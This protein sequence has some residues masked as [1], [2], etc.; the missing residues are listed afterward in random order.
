MSKL[1]MLVATKLKGFIEYWS[2]LHEHK[3]LDPT[4][5]VLKGVIVGPDVTIGRYTYIGANSAI[6]SG[7]IGAFCSISTNVVIGGDDHSMGAVSTHPFWSAPNGWTFSTTD[8]VDRWTQPKSAPV[9]GNDV[10]IGANAVVLRGAV[11]EDGAVIGAGAVV[12]GKIP[13]Y[14]IAVGVP[15]RVIRYRFPADICERLRQS[16]WW[17]W[18]KERLERMR[19]SFANVDEFLEALNVEQYAKAAKSS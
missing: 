6:N 3:Y 11:I 4:I 9:I 5:G 18:E 16:N 10:W 13:A 2:L 1:N 17:D 8:T 15:A 7:N 12:S 14:G 19:A